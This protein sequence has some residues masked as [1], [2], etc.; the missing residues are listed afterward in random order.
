MDQEMPKWQRQVELKRKQIA[1]MIPPA[2]TMTKAELE[3]FTE[4]RKVVGPWFE[5]QQ[6]SDQARRIAYMPVEEITSA[7]EAKQ[8][9]AWE[10][11][12]AFGCRTAKASQIVRLHST[13]ARWRL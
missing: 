3:H 11:F 2:W 10:V 12:N 4:L 7:I 1:S 9:N 8:T 5:A 13:L 6:P